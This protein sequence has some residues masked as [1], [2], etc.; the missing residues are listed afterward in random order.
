MQCSDGSVGIFSNCVV[1]WECGELPLSSILSW[2]AVNPHSIAIRELKFWAACSLL[3]F[4][5]LPCPDGQDSWKS[6]P[7][8]MF[9]IK[10]NAVKEPRQC[11]Q[12]REKRVVWN[13]KSAPKE[14][15]VVNLTQHIYF[16]N[17]V[18][19]LSGSQRHWSSENVNHLRWGEIINCKDSTSSVTKKI[20]KC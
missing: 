17:L 6:F 3:H 1:W 14:S 7:K 10:I 13:I 18:L 12:R 5:S 16:L 20:E 4:L 2:D 19:K 9:R 11:S 15:L 8:S